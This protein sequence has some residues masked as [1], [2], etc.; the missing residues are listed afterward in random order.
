MTVE[1][2][3]QRDA[4]DLH[5]LDVSRYAK[6]IMNLDEIQSLKLCC[7]GFRSVSEMKEWVCSKI[8][9]PNGSVVRDCMSMYTGGESFDVCLT[10]PY[11]GKKCLCSTELCNPAASYHSRINRLTILTMSIIVL[12]SNVVT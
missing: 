10:N 9:R 11:D 1:D 3:I 8:N 5:P 6:K 2:C 12:T 7:P 4:N